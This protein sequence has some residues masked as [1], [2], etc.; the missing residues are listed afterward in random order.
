MHVS[1]VA[2][3]FSGYGQQDAQEFLRFLLEGM[4]DELNRVTSKPKYQ[5]INCDDKP[6]DEQSEIWYKYFRARDDSII[7]DLFEGQ[8]CS[9]LTCSKCG[10]KSRTFD[11]FM[12]LSVSIPRK[13][14]RYS[15]CALSINECLSAFT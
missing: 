8:M 3:Q 12:D 7:S 11:N 14:Y 4:H 1:K 10:Y 13:A 15:G 9:T 5:E 2:R 6:V